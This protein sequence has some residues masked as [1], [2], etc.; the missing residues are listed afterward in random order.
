LVRSR[1]RTG[2]PRIP[3]RAALVAALVV[4][5]LAAPLSAAESDAVAAA[6][7]AV[8]RLRGELELAYLDVQRDHERVR[9]AAWA[10]SSFGDEFS[11]ALT[12]FVRDART[13]D[14]A[15]PT[16]A[17]FDAAAAALRLIASPRVD[18]PLTRTSLSVVLVDAARAS[19]VDRAAAPRDLFVAAAR[20][21]FAPVKV[22]DVWDARFLGTPLVEEYRAAQAKLAAAKKE[23]PPTPP[24]SAKPG[25]E[26]YPG[27]GPAVKPAKSE[28][29]MVFV[30]K[31]RPWIGPWTGWITDVPEKQNKRQQRTVKAV[32]FDRHETTCAQYLA[33]LAA[34]P[35]AARRA[36]LP[37]GW[38]I[39]EKDVAQCPPG[40]ERHPVTGITWRQ[41]QAYAESQGKRLPTSDEWER[42]AAGAE[43]EARA[44]PWG[45]SEEGK[46]WSHLGVEPKGTFPVDAFPDDATPD[47]LIG[48]AGNVAELVA[49]CS[50]RTEIGKSGP[51][52]NKQVLVCG[53][54]FA[55]RVSECATSFRWVLDADEASASVGLRCVM[56]DAEYKKRHK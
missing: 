35:A 45:A 55:S 15:A 7:L 29:D 53:G 51:E 30:D 28:D 31:G 17:D 46:K 12:E 33:Y 44:F 24:P 52:K 26:T 37:Q 48:M 20:R 22:E 47:G 25:S 42:A 32:W 14:D 39:D 23:E 38:P 8:E 6:R 40:K 16:R 19:R 50:D 9:A 21:V 54:S 4:G 27:D 11:S 36:Q 41:A 1:V 5:N 18:P 3:A 34:L 49:T 10:D 43:K 2:W 56:D 13:R